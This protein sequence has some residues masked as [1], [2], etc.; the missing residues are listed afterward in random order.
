MAQDGDTITYTFSDG[1][2]VAEDVSN[3]DEVVVDYLYAAGGQKS[4]VEP[5]SSGG[6][7]SNT[8]IDVSNI[9]TIYIWVSGG[10]EQN[11][12]R[13]NGGSDNQN[14]AG[15]TE[16]SSV[17]TDGNDSPT[18]PFIVAAGGG[19]GA[20]SGDGFLPSPSLLH[21]GG[22]A[23]GGE[24]SSGN[25]GAGDAPP[26]GGDGANT[27]STAT[28]GDGAVSGH[29]STVPITDSGSTTA[30]GG[31]APG[32]DGEIKLSFKSTLSPP[33]PPSNLTAEVQ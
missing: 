2:S 29:G 21:S 33:D 13:Y 15:S 14:G 22:G 31:S 26:V 20:F 8:V 23:R 25:S 16:I 4:G 6:A 7:V 5:P 9:S 24:G 32:N 28:P 19:G 18:E 30:G 3:V 11:Q 10:S 17:N 27:G 1:T 12:G